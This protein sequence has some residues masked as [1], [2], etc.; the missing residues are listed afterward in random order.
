M[1]LIYLVILLIVAAVA[2]SL[3]NRYVKMASGTKRIL[4]LVVV[5]VAFAL[6]LQ[7]AGLW[8]DIGRLHMKH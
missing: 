3:V 7:A 4:N 1:P 8:G 5:A 6:V 2:L